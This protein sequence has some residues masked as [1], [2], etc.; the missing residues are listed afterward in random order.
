MQ[1]VL[2]ILHIAGTYLLLSE[3]LELCLLRQLDVHR[4]L[5]AR[6]LLV[7]LAAM[8]VAHYL[9]IRH[10]VGRD[11]SCGEAVLATQEVQPLDVEL[12]DCLAHIADATALRYIYPRQA[13]QAILQRHVT[14]A[15]ERSQMMAQRIA[16]LLQ[17]VGAHHHLL[18]A[19]ALRSQQHVDLCQLILQREAF[20][21]LLIADVAE[22]QGDLSRW[23]TL[24]FKVIH[25]LRIGGAECQ[26]LVAT[27]Q[28]NDHLT[29][30]L[31]AQT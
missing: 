29:H 4:Y 30:R 13:L 21:F 28:L 31:V 27:H 8:V 22:H 18:Q 23:R 10:I 16:H 15:E 5:V 7:Y 6:E 9:Y 3:G 24:Q 2:T 17:R 25:A 26:Y 12:R 11:V 20:R 1:P 14:F 19:D